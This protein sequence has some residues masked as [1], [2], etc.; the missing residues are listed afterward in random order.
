MSRTPFDPSYEELP[1]VLPIF[2]LG[3]VLLLPGGRLPL[4]IFEPRYLAMCDD[5][6]AGNRMI[7]MIQPTEEETEERAPDVYETGCA[8]R[9]V[10]F[11]ETDDGRYLITLAGLIRFD[12]R[13]EL[14]AKSYRLVEP[15]Y[16]RFKDDLEEASG[17]IDRDHLLEVLREYF[18]VHSIEGDWSVISQATDEGLVTALAMIC[19]LGGPEKQA[20]LEAMT[21]TERA[22]TLTAIMEMSLHNESGETLRH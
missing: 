8:G 19:P 22:E 7:G 18:T 6:L 15:D 4:N 11:S 17:D 20:L 14:P 16:H 2:P 5:A 1:D 3:E 13:A 12:V 9:I 10:S 21:L